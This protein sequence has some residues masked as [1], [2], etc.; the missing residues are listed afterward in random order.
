MQGGLRTADKPTTF[1]LNAELAGLV[2]T[3]TE[4][5]DALRLVASNIEAQGIGISVSGNVLVG[6][7]PVGTWRLSS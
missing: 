5:A 3:P 2:S 1:Q 4:L 6:T 7:S